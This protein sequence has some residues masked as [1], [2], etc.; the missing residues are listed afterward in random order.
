MMDNFMAWFI[1]FVLVGSLLAATCWPF[2]MV[3]V[4]LH[5]VCKWW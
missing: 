2:V 4:I 3:F 5:F 1:R